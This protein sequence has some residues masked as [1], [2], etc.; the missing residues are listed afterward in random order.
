MTAQRPRAHS[1]GMDICVRVLD[2]TL[3]L[4]AYARP[5]DAGLDLYA[6]VGDGGL[7]LEPGETEAVKTGVAL[8]IPA[9]IV[10][11]IHPRFGLAKKHG[12]SLIHAPRTIDSG[13]RG[14]V[15]VLLHNTSAEPFDIA[16]GDRIARIVFQMFETVTLRPVA[17]LKASRLGVGGF[18][19]TGVS[20]ELRRVA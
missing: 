10:G 8:E 13:F 9:G 12:I 1:L 7:A 17:H 15:A 20:D 4:P 11:F 2:N 14:E 19:S 18:G 6:S 16:H 3:P 5:G